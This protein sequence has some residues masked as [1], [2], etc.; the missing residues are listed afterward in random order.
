MLL[1]HSFIFQTLTKVYSSNYKS[2]EVLSFASLLTDAVVI[3]ILGS[4]PFTTTSPIE[5]GTWEF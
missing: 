3:N 2:N 1:V 4:L 5:S